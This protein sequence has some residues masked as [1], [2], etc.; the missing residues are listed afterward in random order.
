MSALLNYYN[1]IIDHGPLSSRQTSIETVLVLLLMSTLLI[2]NKEKWSTEE[3]I[4]R[5]AVWSY[6]Y[7][8]F[9]FTF[10]ARS[11]KMDYNYNLLPF[12][13]YQHISVTHDV[14]YV[15]EILIN[16]LMFVPVGILVPWAYQ[17]YLHDDQRKERNTVILFGLIVS[18]SVECIQLF[19]KTGLFEWDDIIHN[20]IGLIVGYGF[21]LRIRGKAFSEVH[22]YF[23]PMIGVGIALLILML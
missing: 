7:L 17:N 5:I 18:V 8:I 22:W 3:K 6:L 9:L 14:F 2:L 1:F 13:T 11:T 20:M 19:T 16:C 12:W 21:Y 4:G 10:L 23:L 15:L